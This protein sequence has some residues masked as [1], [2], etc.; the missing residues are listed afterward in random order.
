M[1]Q[2]RR[3]GQVVTYLPDGTIKRVTVTSRVGNPDGS[4]T[5]TRSDGRVYTTLPSRQQPTAQAVKQHAIDV[6]LFEAARAAYRMEQ[7]EKGKPAHSKVGLHWPYCGVL[8]STFAEY[9]DT[10]DASV[11][12]EYLVS[13]YRIG[14]LDGHPATGG[15]IFYLHG[16]GES[17]GRV[18]RAKGSAILA[19][20][21]IQPR[22]AVK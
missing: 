20:A 16:E 3:N 6:L 9:L 12:R 18:S 22:R 10:D 4:Q 13:L 15:V 19:A 11:I 21:G 14:V 2:S 17:S 8:A 5:V 1:D 7:A